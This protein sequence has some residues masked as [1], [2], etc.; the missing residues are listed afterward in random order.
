MADV[1]V[2]RKGPSESRNLERSNQGTWRGEQYPGSM[3]PWNF[4][5]MN[6]FALM[7][8]MMSESEPFFGG[9]WSGTSEFGWSP[10]VEI[11]E[12]DDSLLVRADLPG[13]SQ[14]DVKV[15]VTDEGLV[16]Q[17]ER[18]REHEEKTRTGYRS[19]RSYGKFY[20][21]IR[22]PDGAKAEQARAQFNNGV[23][24]VTIPIP[25]GARRRRQIPITTGTSDRKPVSSQSPQQQAEARTR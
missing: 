19:E 8:R 23:L 7:R 15:E 9:P 21:T 6:P 17:G 1:N 12:H 25:D 11:S 2:E 10:A 24:E 18:K 13:L 20:R 4:F 3:S 22:L 16:I 5:S 14:D